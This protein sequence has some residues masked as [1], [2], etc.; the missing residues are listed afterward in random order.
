MLFLVISTPRADPPSSMRERQKA[1]WAWLNERMAEGKVQHIWNKAGRGA[2]AIVDL[3][4]NEELHKLVNQWQEI[5]PATFEITALI[6]K[7]YQERIA[8]AGTNPMQL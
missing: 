5:V 7:E 4:S 6:S 2:V 3:P 8:N 1:Y